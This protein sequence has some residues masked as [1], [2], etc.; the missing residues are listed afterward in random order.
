MARVP[1]ELATTVATLPP[2]YAA[3]GIVESAQRRDLDPVEVARTHFRLG[4]RLQFGRLLERI[5]ALPR[6]DRWQSM[7]RAA[8]RDELHATHAALTAQVLDATPEGGEPEARVTHWE[9]QTGVILV[10]ARSRLHE[11]LDSETWDLA[12]LSVALR[13][14]RTLV[15]AP[16]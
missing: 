14:V 11:I 8:L 7:V 3:L 16:M 10:R 4:E 9:E 1:V 6:E 12:R 15:N 5:I 2:A 13:V